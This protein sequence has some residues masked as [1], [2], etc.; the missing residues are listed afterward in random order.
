MIRRLLTCSIPL[1]LC[2]ALAGCGGQSAPTAIPTV[3]PAIYNQVPDTTVFE[4]GQCSVVLSEPA[5]AHTSNTLGGEPS[6][7]IAAG[8]YE[9]GVAAQYDTSVWY[10]LN[11]V[12]SANFINSTSVS[13]TEG[14]CTLDLDE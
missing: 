10:M 4:P 2:L 5:P 6:G 9:V 14:D 13:S 8:T 7:E 3:D 12:G 1:A 11:D